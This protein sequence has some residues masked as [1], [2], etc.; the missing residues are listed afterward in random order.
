MLKTTIEASDLGIVNR[1]IAGNLRVSIWSARKKLTARDLGD[2]DLPPD[3]LASLGSKKICDPASLAI[4]HTLKGRAI[5][6]LNY[7]GLEFLGGWAIPESKAMEVHQKLDSLERE[8]NEAKEEF[9]LNYNSNVQNWVDRQNEWSSIIED[10]VESAEYVRGRISFQSRFYSVAMP[11]MSGE[12][13]DALCDG[14]QDEVAQAA[15][16]AWQTS[17]KEQDRISR[18]ALSPI[19]KIH[20]KLTSFSFVDPIVLP[21]IEIIKAALDCLPPKGHID[22]LPLIQLQ[23]L[24]SLLRDTEALADLAKRKMNGLATNDDILAGFIPSGMLPAVEP[25][26]DQ[27]GEFD[28]EATPASADE[29]RADQGGQEERTENDA[30]AVAQQSAPGVIPL[31]PTLSGK[32][33]QPSLFDCAQTLPPIPVA[34]PATAPAETAGTFINVAEAPVPQAVPVIVPEEPEDD[35]VIQAEEIQPA[36]VMPVLPGGMGDFLGGFI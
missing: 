19:R 15:K 1:L 21:V 23:G 27:S 28:S 30:W 14:F 10:S 3:D 13:S 8:F 33:G 31:I 12:G 18:R 20:D 32:H 4:F 36:I 26:E 16:Y 2:T 17:F 5:G 25:A 7:Y 6:V 34:Q 24:L 22:G 35:D 11:G 9:L 29:A